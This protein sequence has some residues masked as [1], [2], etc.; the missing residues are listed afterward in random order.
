M[1]SLLLRSGRTR[2]DLVPIYSGGN[3]WLLW[4]IR[5]APVNGILSV[6]PLIFL[7]VR[8]RAS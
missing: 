1:T 8:L 5:G 4:T 2:W 7:A 3:N 6:F